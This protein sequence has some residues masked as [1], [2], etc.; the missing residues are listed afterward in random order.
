MS[1][2]NL[3]ESYLSRVKVASSIRITAILIIPFV[4][5]SLPLAAIAEESIYDNAQSLMDEGK[6]DEAEAAL[7]KRLSSD[8]K[9]VVALSLLGEVYHRKND[10]DKAIKF[11][12]K[13]VSIDPKYPAAY[14]YRGKLYF[15][16]QKFD[17]AADEFS[18]YIENMRPLIISSPENIDQYI[19]NLHDISQISF[20]LKRYDLLYETL[21]DILRLSPKDQ[22]ATYNMGIYYYIYERDR[23]KSY[24]YFTKAVELDPSTQ[25]ASKARYAIEF[26]RSNPDPRVEPDFSFID[27]EYRD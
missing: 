18:L 20:E 22:P 26:M 3:P 21:S 13:A 19:A 4:L 15:S 12:D 10:R 14:L 9:D 16:M 24:S 2:K 11:L 25:T 8:D 5:I 1:A 27:K 17:E 6:F 23:P 7:N